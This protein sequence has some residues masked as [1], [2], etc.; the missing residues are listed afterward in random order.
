MTVEESLTEEQQE[1][2]ESAAEML[3]GLI[4][5]RYV[6]TNR[7]MQAMYE[8]YA[9]ASFGRCPRAFCCG[10]PGLPVGRSDVPRNYT[11]HIYCPMCRDIFT[12]RSSRSASIDGAYFGT[13]FPHLF[14]MT[15]PELIPQQ[16]AQG[17]VP[18][19]FGFRI[20]QNSPYYAAARSSQGAVKRR[21]KPV[22]RRG[23]A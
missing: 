21:S 10:Q 12:P 9:S 3:Y 2:V 22:R 16:N 11:V 13:T 6:I 23:G 15:F 4:H 19:V 5:A 8:K 7:G 20:H 17:Y 1:L 18:R 14:L